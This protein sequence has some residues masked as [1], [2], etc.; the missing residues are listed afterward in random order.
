MWDFLTVLNNKIIQKKIIITK[1]E[2]VMC[3]KYIENC[4]IILQLFPINLPTY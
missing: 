3:P 4:Y 1:N 2:K